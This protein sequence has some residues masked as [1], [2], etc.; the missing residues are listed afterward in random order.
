MERLFESGGSGLLSRVAGAIHD[1]RARVRQWRELE[2][3]ASC[4]VLDDILADVGASRAE[5]PI[6]MHAYPGS[7]RRHAEMM[8]WMGVDRKSLPATAEIRDAQW[9][10]V[11]CAAWHECDDWL[12]SPESKRAVPGFCPNLGTFWRFR[13]AQ[14]RRAAANEEPGARL[15]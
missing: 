10:C 8:R 4:G 1:W 9:R 3:L 13:A 2:D 12:R 15:T 11:R 5:I 14:A 6:I 7:A